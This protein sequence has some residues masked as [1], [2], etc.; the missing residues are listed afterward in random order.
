MGG[1][2]VSCLPARG[3]PVRR[4]RGSLNTQ[5]WKLSSRACGKC[6]TQL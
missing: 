3:G 6:T 5:I 4:R 2:R 1:D